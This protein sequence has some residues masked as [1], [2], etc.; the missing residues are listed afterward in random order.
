MLDVI[1]DVFDDMFASGATFDTHVEITALEDTR[2]DGPDGSRQTLTARM[3]LMTVVNQYDIVVTTFVRE[4]Q[5]RLDMVEAT[6]LRRGNFD[7]RQEPV[8]LGHG[9]L[10]ETLIRDIFHKMFANE[11]LSIWNPSRSVQ[12]LLD[13]EQTEA[14][15][16]QPG[17]IHDAPKTRQ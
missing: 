10:S 14:I 2:V 5:A 13:S 17:Y 9:P 16:N 15:T 6:A 11:L 3:R 12:L 4:G 7:I 1:R 8:S